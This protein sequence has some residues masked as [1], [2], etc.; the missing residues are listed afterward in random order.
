MGVGTIVRVFG[1]LLAHLRLLRRDLLFALWLEGN[2]PTRLLAKGGAYVETT[3][4]GRE[5]AYAVE[6]LGDR[7]DVASPADVARAHMAVQVVF[8][9]G[10]RWMDGS[11]GWD[12][13][14]TRHSLLFDSATGDWGQMET[15]VPTLRTNDAAYR[16]PNKCFQKAQGSWDPFGDVLKEPLSF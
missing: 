13:F 12:S 15:Q 9:H 16:D 7:C 1:I 6:V 4:P 14:K 2:Q 8:R 5:H 3:G 10:P 11:R